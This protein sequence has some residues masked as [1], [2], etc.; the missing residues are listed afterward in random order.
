[1]NRYTKLDATGADLPKDAE[2]WVAVRGN[3]LVLIDG[4]HRH[5]VW[6]RHES[7]AR[8]SHKD[9]IAAAA[10]VTV[11]GWT[12]WRL[13]TVEELATLPDRSRFNPAIDTDYFSSNGAWCWSST[14]DAS[15]PAFAWLVSFHDGLVGYYPRHNSGFVRAVRSVPPSQ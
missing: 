10:A 7:T 11:G 14:V 3:H 9:A 13:P 8:Y 2:D 15:D 6:P 5:L 12:D 1:M 4:E